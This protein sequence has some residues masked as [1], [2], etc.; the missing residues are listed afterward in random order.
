MKSRGFTLL[1]LMIILTIIAGLTVLAIPNLI[2]AKI[3]AN[4]SFL[5][6]GP[7]REE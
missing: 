2:R 1:E 4:D 7:V 5:S 6:G 3:A